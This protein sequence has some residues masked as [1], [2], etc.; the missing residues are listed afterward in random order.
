[1][2]RGFGSSLALILA[3][4][5]APGHAQDAA[6][7]QAAQTGQPEAQYRLG[8]LYQ[9]GDG[10]LQNFATAAEW[11]AKAAY[12]GHAGAQ[13]RLARHL[14]EGLGVPRDTVAALEWFAKAAASGDAQMQYD[15]AVAR[16]ALATGPEDLT[17]AANWY[18]KAA[19]QGHTDAQVSLG[20]M[21][22]NGEGV[23]RDPAR[24][25]ALYEG[26]AAQGHARAQNNLGLLYVRGEGVE[27]DYA[28]A[29]QL[30]QQAADQGMRVAMTNLG[31]MYENAFGVPLD[32]ERAHELYRMGG[33]GETDKTGLSLPL[34]DPR[35]LPPDSSK[36]G[37]ARLYRAAQ[38]GDPVAQFQMGWVL[39]SQPQP[40]FA[41]QARAASLMRAAAEAGYT[42]AMANLGW[43]YFQG[44]AV[45][46]DYVLGH[47]W[48][49]LASSG[50]D[51]QILA[52]NAQLSRVMPPAQIDEAQTRAKAHLRRRKNGGPD[53]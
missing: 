18:A 6:L 24:A 25:R 1:M 37:L 3:L 8:L 10:V 42:P 32:E 16:Q 33:Q 5:A 7:L 9:D 2:R 40:E 31:V 49:V 45:P 38:A 51:A 19:E 27:Q 47:M 28:R 14:Y 53:N 4:L 34:Y 44:M 41:D 43:M 22:Q 23:P 46:Q 30:F 11:Y 52:L 20:L 13:N 35:L 36:E 48:L 15:Y 26:P 50:G 21:Y 12:Q 29:A 17:D 39:L